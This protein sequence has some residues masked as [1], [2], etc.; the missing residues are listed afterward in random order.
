M[1][2]MVLNEIQKTRE[3]ECCHGQSEATTNFV[4]RIQ[5][6]QPLVIGPVIGVEIFRPPAMQFGTVQMARRPPNVSCVIEL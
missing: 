3:K 5:P 2:P 1:K 4:P 6:C